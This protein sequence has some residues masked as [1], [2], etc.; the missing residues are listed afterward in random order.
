[1]NETIQLRPLRER[2]FARDRRSASAA[3]RFTA[4]TLVG[5]G[6]A[7]RARADDV[8]LCVSELVTNALVH[9]VPPG[10][11][12][13]LL[14]RYD[15]C[16][17]RVEVHDSGPGVPHVVD[18]AD[19]GGRGLLLVAA[20]S[21]KWGVR[22]RESGKAVWCEFGSGPVGRCHELGGEKVLVGGEDLLRG[23][24]FAGERVGDQVQACQ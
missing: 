8:V 18:D 5:W 6:L 21:D 9:G 10:R 16:V 4:E 1:M 13:R 3:R 19:E 22:E 11:R 20:L 15:G 14:L 12:L 2:F 17:L 23:E 24:T 7:E